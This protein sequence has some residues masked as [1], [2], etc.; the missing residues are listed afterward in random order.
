MGAAI[1]VPGGRA[2]VMPVQIAQAGRQDA[3]QGEGGVPGLDACAERSDMCRENF[4]AP[5]PLY[6]WD[7]LWYY[8]HMAKYKWQGPVLPKNA[9]ADRHEFIPVPGHPGRRAHA[10]GRIMNEHERVLRGS[11]D[12]RGYIGVASYGSGSKSPVNKAHRLVALAFVPNPENKP[13][14]NHIN[15]IKDDNRACNLEWV[16]AQENVDHAW[17]TGLMKAPVPR[18]RPNKNRRILP[19]DVKDMRKLHEAGAT[20]AS[21][22]R[23]YGISRPHASNL[24]HAARV[25][26]FKEE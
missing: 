15:G 3:C 22:A 17:R 5:R 19:S 26:W 24:I 1:T 14:V 10:D 13:Q 20:V 2:R 12:Q 23:V 9:P 11:P 25:P 7:I 8:K 18:S 16:T 21:I 6:T 4:L